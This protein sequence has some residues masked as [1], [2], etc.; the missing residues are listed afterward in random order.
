MHKNYCTSEHKLKCANNKRNFTLTAQEI[1][2]YP[3]YV[4]ILAARQNLFEM[5]LPRN[6]NGADFRKSFTLDFALVHFVRVQ[7][8]L[9]TVKHLLQIVV[10]AAAANT[11]ILGVV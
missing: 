2:L 5:L 9:S 4:C 3:G 10:V 1:S 8:P 11:I 7:F 6:K